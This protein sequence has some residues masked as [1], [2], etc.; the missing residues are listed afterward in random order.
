M[1]AQPQPTAI[2]PPVATRLP[3]GH[4]TS[5]PVRLLRL[6]QRPAPARHEWLLDQP[7]EKMLCDFDP[8][9]AGGRNYPQQA[10]ESTAKRLLK[11]VRHRDDQ[12]TTSGFSRSKPGAPAYARLRVAD[13]I[14]PYWQLRMPRRTRCSFRPYV[15]PP[16]FTRY[17]LPDP[18]YGGYATLPGPRQS[19]RPQQ[20][21]C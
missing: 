5:F 14:R 10:L 19:A 1:A 6:P 11:P 7:A 2:F 12:R 13:A 17:C 15:I 21:R 18:M 3:N 20:T 4:Q 8:V 9:L 16:A